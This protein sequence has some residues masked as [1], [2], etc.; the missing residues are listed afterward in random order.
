[1]PGDLGERVL[2]PFLLQL[3]GAAGGDAKIEAFAGAPH[4][5]GREPAHKDRLIAAAKAY[6]EQHTAATV[7][8]SRPSQ[9][10]PPGRCPGGRGVPGDED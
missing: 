10:R 9:G 5:F 2:T 4:G 8:V 7:A 6:I 3:Y 1:M